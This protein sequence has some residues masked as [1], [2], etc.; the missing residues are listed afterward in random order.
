MK[1]FEN[2]LLNTSGFRFIMEERITENLFVF[3]KG[4]Q[5]LQKSAYKAKRPWDSVPNPVNF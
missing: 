2:P 4:S 3:K 5:T 1:K